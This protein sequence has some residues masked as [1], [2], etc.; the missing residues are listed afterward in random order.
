MIKIGILVNTTYSTS[1]IVENGT[2]LELL[3]AY[4]R[5][6]C[7]QPVTW[8]AERRMG[9]TLLMIKLLIKLY[10]SGDYIPHVSSTT[11]GLPDAYDD[12]K[13]FVQEIIQLYTICDLL[14][15]ATA[16]SSITEKGTSMVLDVIESLS[17][18][19]DWIIEE[20]EGWRGYKEV[21]HNLVY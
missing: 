3:W 6:T 21:T 16:P 14:L 8:R 15:K 19:L 7:H 5:S 17:V 18:D 4:H 12:Q 9:T 11:D 1:T 20:K 2:L 10:H 13:A